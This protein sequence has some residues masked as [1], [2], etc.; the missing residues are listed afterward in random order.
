MKCLMC[1]HV[2]LRSYPKHANVGLGRCK[3]EKVS[4]VFESFEKE[5]QCDNYELADA[6][7]VIKRLA[8]Y[9]KGA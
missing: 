4:G 1:A 2:D 3:L 8:W 7:K 6:E 9:E 5:R